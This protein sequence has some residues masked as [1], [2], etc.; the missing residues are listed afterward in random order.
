[1]HNDL[2]PAGWIPPEHFKTIVRYSP[3][4]SLDL[5]IL[6][7]RGHVLVGL[8]RNEPARNTWFVPGGIIRKDET[9]DSAF[10]RIL[11]AETGLSK[12]RRDAHHIG[13]FEHFYP[14]NR[15][16]DTGYGTHYV[17]NAYR[18]ELPSRP[19]IHLD[20]QHAEIR[21]MVPRDLLAAP[22]V[23]ENTKIY[24]R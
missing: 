17:V 8:R 21:W 10:G 22:D 14:T 24:F 5:V 9:L 15:Y 11:F 16:L 1:M 3:L 4:V 12:A 19:A 18:I 23:H 20:D 2:H 6:D 7:E 13:L